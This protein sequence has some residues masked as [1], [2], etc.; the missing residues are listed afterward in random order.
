MNH[1]QD[2]CQ[3]LKKKQR[4]KGEISQGRHRY[5][6]RQ[7]ERCSGEK[8]ICTSLYLFLLSHKNA[9]FNPK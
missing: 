1:G 7:R 4:I 9:V 3:I 8:R 5:Q 2:Q 6:D